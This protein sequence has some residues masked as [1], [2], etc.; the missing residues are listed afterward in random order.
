MN[1]TRPAHSVIGQ[2]SVTS[3]LWESDG[4]VYHIHIPFAIAFVHGVVTP[5]RYERYKHMTRKMLRVNSSWEH[6]IVLTRS[7]STRVSCLMNIC[8][9]T[10]EAHRDG[11]M[12]LSSLS[13][14]RKRFG[15]HMVL[16]QHIRANL[17]CIDTHLCTVRDY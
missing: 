9:C 16:T 1:P 15:V 17:R 6:A 5:F 4:L 8:I 2:F 13:H 7:H 10:V 12:I 14:F 3:G 11:I